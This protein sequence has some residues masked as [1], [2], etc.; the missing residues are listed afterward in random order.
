M[1][2]CYE[3]NV[4]G[5]IILL[6]EESLPK[7]FVRQVKSLQDDS[8]TGIINGLEVVVQLPDRQQ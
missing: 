1:A 8:L 5:C 6:A 4:L 3:V 7:D 2:L